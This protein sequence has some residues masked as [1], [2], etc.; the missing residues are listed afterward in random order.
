MKIAHLSDLHVLSLAGVSPLRLWT[1]KRATGMI[2]LKLHRKSKHKPSAIAAVVDDLRAQQPEH[3]IIT[4]DLSNLSLESE[5]SAVQRVL[6]SLALSTEQVS[7][8]P[9]NHD[10]YTRGAQR[11]QR[12]YRAFSQY[13]QSDLAV[14]GADRA[15]PSGVFPFVQ[16]RGPIAVI[17]LS[18]AVVR[19]PVLSS[20]WLGDRQLALFSEALS[21]PAVRDKTVLVMMHHPVINPKNRWRKYSRGFAEADAV[22]QVLCGRERVVFAHGHLHQAATRV[23][24]TPS[25]FAVHHLGASSASLVDDGGYNIYT[26]NESGLVATERRLLS[27]NSQR[28]ESGVVPPRDSAFAG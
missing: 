12:F 3:L 4:G 28:F 8:V 21:H 15:H 13:M 9:G 11:S 1:N 23:L 7:V 22:A 25:G 5:F 17:G 10:V 2:N 20:G 26:I 14:D 16:L 18:S 27:H 19:P 6:D 24:Q